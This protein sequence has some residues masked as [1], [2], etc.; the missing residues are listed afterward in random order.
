MVYLAGNY[1]TS[2]GCC[3]S[4]SFF[5]ATLRNRRLVQSLILGFKV[6]VV[7]VRIRRSDIEIDG[8]IHLQQSISQRG[9]KWQKHQHQSV[10]NQA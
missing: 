9:E 2:S 10:Q 7:E 4:V 5:K 8:F 1:W 3:G 6:A